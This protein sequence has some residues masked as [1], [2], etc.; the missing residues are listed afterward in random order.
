[1]ATTFQRPRGEQMIEVEEAQRRVLAEVAV[2]EAEDVALVDALGRVLRQDV[3]AP[4]DVPQRDNSAMDGYAVRAEDVADAPVSL[5][6]IEDLPA[7]TVATKRVDAGTAIRIMTGA[8]LP[9]GADAVV[10]VELTDAGSE[11]VRIHEAVPRGANVRSRGEDMHAG[12]VVLADGTPIRAGE[13]GVLAS[14]QQ[15]VVRVGRRPEIAIFSTGDEVIDVDAPRAIGKVVNSNV[16]AL[17]ALAREAGALPRVLPIVP[18]RAEATV[19]AIESALTSDFVVSSGGVSA[20]AFDFVKDAL[21]SL[22][23][24]TKFWQVAMKP[25]KP[26][27]LS[28]LRERLYFGLPGNPVSCMVSFLLFV[29]PSIRKAMGQRR[30]IL[31]PIANVRLAAPIRTKGDRRTYFRV[32][33]VASD[34][35]LVAHPAPAQG[36]G[37]LTSMIGANGLAILERGTTRAESGSVVPA[38]LIGSVAGE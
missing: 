13:L 38:V 14:V 6:V 1:M 5:R 9:E 22:G 28:R 25:G 8:L 29:A 21:D 2:F 12:D 17:A 24:E 35:E 7:G 16:Y 15:R 31:P 34:G 30:A 3:V 18:D 10:Q 11:V 19:A 4:E 33:V 32:R 23:A 27:V 26:V 20:G 37:V 36:S